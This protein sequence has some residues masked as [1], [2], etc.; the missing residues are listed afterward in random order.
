MSS[1]TKKVLVGLLAALLLAVAVPS[2]PVRVSADG[3]PTPTP[4]AAQPNGPLPCG[5]G[6]KE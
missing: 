4:T 3:D 6:C 1:K 5:S 2:Q